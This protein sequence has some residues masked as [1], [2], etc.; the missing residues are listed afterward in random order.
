MKRGIAA[1]LAALLFGSLL[2]LT[3]AAF[4]DEK[5]IEADFRAAVKEM[6]ERKILG[7]FT[8]G[9]FKPK[10]T[11]T[12]AQAA[13][14]LCVMLEGEEKANALTKTET[15]FADVPATHWAAR[16]VAYCV[17]KNIVA[18]VGDGRFDPD[19]KLSSAAFAKMLLVAY[20]A[21]ASKMTGA[22]WIAGVKE[23]A[24]PTIL[25]H[26]VKGFG[27]A[28]LSRQEA[29][30]MA[31]NALFYA[32]SQAAKTQKDTS[33]ELP[34]S[35]PESLKVLA[36]GNSFSNDCILGYLWPM[37]KDVGV[38]AL[39]IGNLY[40]G[41]C[42]LQ[43]HTGYAL[44]EKKAYRYYKRTDKDSK[45]NSPKDNT[46]TLDDPLKDEQW[47]AITFQHGQS[48]F[49]MEEYYQPDLDVL[50]YYV[51]RS[52]PK[53]IFGWNF[54]WA[55]PQGCTKTNV[56]QY[57]GGDQMKMYNMSV[58]ATKNKILTEPRIK[59]VLPVGT[60]IQNAR[61]S[62][63][64]DH[65]DRD[66]YHL[67]KGIGRYIA[68]MTWCCMLTGASPDQVKYLPEALLDY[69][70]EGLNKDTPG[71]LDKLGEIARESV[72]NALAKPYEITQSQLTT[73]LK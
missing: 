16:F 64:G 41:G 15:G 31:Y 47:D 30:Q 46:S 35:V 23:A 21:D 3:G 52:Q 68:S 19:G 27:T 48:R 66:G 49:G 38:K 55:A 33:R 60:A 57:Y 45:W 69:L 6:A 17:D 28:A 39:T 11:L 58:A 8:D 34:T 65:L 1:I 2:S 20:G 43:M 51:Q 36:I 71:M 42:S 40:H 72:K 37:M 24:K 7:G 9:S 26:N 59:F 22:D 44:E 70:P 12:R 56:V 62:F 50:L 32:E 29:A 67:N 63:L 5:S 53:A 73:A 18:G 61:T 10:Q 54:V 25:A 13:K 4:T 14:I